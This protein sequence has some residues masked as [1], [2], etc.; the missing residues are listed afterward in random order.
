[1]DTNLEDTIAERN[2]IFVASGFAMKAILLIKRV[3]GGWFIVQR[4]NLSVSTSTG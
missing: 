4:R 3:N 1:M 2:E